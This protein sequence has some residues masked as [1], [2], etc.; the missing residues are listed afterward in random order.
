MTDGT[1]SSHG[2]AGD[3]LLL[4]FDADGSFEDRL[5]FLRSEFKG[6]RNEGDGWCE[7]RLMY[8]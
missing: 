4:K 7:I 6:E 1:G 3:V 2:T 8:N 5:F